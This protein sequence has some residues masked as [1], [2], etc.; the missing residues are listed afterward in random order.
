MKQ[1]IFITLPL[2]ES[3]EAHFI[4]VLENIKRKKKTFI[5]GLDL[6][7]EELIG[8]QKV[9]I[10]RCLK[11]KGHAQKKQNYYILI[12]LW[13]LCVSLDHKTSHK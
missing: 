11:N 3:L 1:I 10:W 7:Y 8:W 6:Y 4:S 2:I 5:V 9:T 13:R 12:K